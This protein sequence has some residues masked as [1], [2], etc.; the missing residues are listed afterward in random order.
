MIHSKHNLPDGLPACIAQGK[1]G[2]RILQDLLGISN[3]KQ[4]QSILHAEAVQ[5]YLQSES[6]QLRGL[7]TS[8]RV[9]KKVMAFFGRTD[10]RRESWALYCPLGADIPPVDDQGFVPSLEYAALNRYCPGFPEQ[11]IDMDRVE[12]AFN[13]II[14]FR[15]SS[16][17]PNLEEPALAVW[18]ALRED[19]LRWDSLPSD[20]QEAVVLAT[21]AVASILDDVRPLAWA[22]GQTERLAAEFAFAVDAATEKSLDPVNSAQG[23]GLGSPSGPERVLQEWNHTCD[24]IM[25]IAAEL[26][27]S[28]PE[29]QRV[30]DL[31]EP[32]QRLEDLRA[33]VLTLIDIRNR[34]ATVRRVTDILT[35][36]ANDLSAPWLQA[37]GDKVHAQW[38][39]AYRDPSSV[40]EEEVEKDLER[41]QDELKRELQRWR[42]FEDTKANLLAELSDLE[43]SGESDLEAQLEAETNEERIHAGIAD[44]ARQATSC[45]RGILAAVAPAGQEFDPSK[46][47]E[48][49][50]A[51]AGAIPVLAEAAVRL[52]HDEPDAGEDRDPEDPGPG[53]SST[54]NH[55]TDGA[56][57]VSSRKS[58]S[59]SAR[60]TDTLP[61]AAP[62]SNLGLG[63]FA[64]SSL[65]DRRGAKA[66]DAPSEIEEARIGHPEAAEDRFWT[67]AWKPWLELIGDPANP[68][69]VKPWNPT[70]VPDC[71]ATSPFADPS[72][73]A[74]SLA[75]KL[76]NGLVRCPRD[77]LLPLV[78]FLNSDPL[79][80]RPEWKEIYW[81]ILNYCLREELDSKDSQA[82]ALSL[83]A[84]ILKT[85]PSNIEYRHLVDSADR[86]TALPPQFQNVKWALELSVPFLVNRCEDLDYLSVYLDSVH[87]YV[88]M[89]G[90]HLASKHQDMWNDIKKFL[91]RHESDR[92]QPPSASEST[93][94]LR[95][96]SSFLKGKS[97]VIY[98]LQRSAALTARDRI[99]AIESS[100]E[101]RLLHDKVWSDSLQDPIRNADLCVMVKSAATHAVTEMISRTRRKAG[102]EL[103]VPSWKGVHSLLRA[104]YDAA[105][106]AKGSAIAPR[107]QGA[108][109][110][111]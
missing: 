58:E 18:P 1:K 81:Q 36:C 70:R 77:T 2:L 103:I 68:D 84:L 23:D 92:A 85:N 47:Y 62:A 41:V 91:A 67:G 90:F 12:R 29:P 43:V 65:S 49:D 6:L 80:G 88:S 93:E 26:K 105:R 111:A 34:E 83:I 52:N 100:T 53:G 38:Q 28:S 33:Q 108:G 35:A 78:E 55:G 13:G 17:L 95:N 104:I 64:A 40:P 63:D 25:D 72:G 73:F 97:L 22:A 20:R 82:M 60:E 27:S 10:A 96:L 57:Q 106:S 102:K 75:R 74:E 48:A 54:S 46:D 51:E 31:L 39:L 76:R 8:Q 15:H 7:T 24:L 9:A 89:A 94:E 42:N 30:G 11:D 79:K 32:V 21:F 3:R 44:A 107:L 4:W 16:R 19:L 50:L 98:T 61:S 110:A 37:V 99:Q 5:D 59:V 87:Q 45:K 101:I 56:S 66:V 86:L 109:R 71:S 14:G 69:R